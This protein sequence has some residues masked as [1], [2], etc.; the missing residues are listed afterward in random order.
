MG[1]GGI[2]VDMNGRTVFVFRISGCSCAVVSMGRI[3]DLSLFRSS[4]SM[5]KDCN[6]VRILFGILGY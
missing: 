6:F 3:L 1:P 2:A 5:L 4:S